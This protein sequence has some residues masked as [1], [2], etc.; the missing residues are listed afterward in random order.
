[1]YSGENVG[2]GPES[3]LEFDSALCRQGVSLGPRS[4]KGLVNIKRK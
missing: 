1:M 4:S 2:T 3:G